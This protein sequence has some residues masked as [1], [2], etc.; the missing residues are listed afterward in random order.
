M[1]NQA[2]PLAKAWWNKSDGTKLCK[3]IEDR[4]INPSEYD[5]SAIEKIQKYWPHKN[6]MMF[7][8]L[9][10]TKLRD[11]EMDQVLGGARGKF[12]AL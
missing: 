9:F 1:I 12:S 8:Q 7:A 2:N 3:L 11:W 10:R 5:C 6:F 4:I